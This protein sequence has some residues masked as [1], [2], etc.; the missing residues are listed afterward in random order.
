MPYVK[1]DS[2]GSITAISTEKTPT[3]AEWIELD[4][5]ELKQYLL[6]LAGGGHRPE[7]ANALEASDHA[8]IRVVDDLVNVLI[9]KNLMRFTDL[10]DAAQKKLLERQSLR[11]SLTALKLLGDDDQGLI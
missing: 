8:L 11:Q 9:E 5:P 7:L 10:P 1:R 4:A 2:T 6:R 3:I